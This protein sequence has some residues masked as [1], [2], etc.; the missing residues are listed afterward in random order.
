MIKHPCRLWRATERREGTRKKLRGATKFMF[1]YDRQYINSF[2]IT[3]M[4]KSTF[5]FL[6]LLL[7][8]NILKYQ[9]FTLIQHRISNRIQIYWD[10]VNSNQIFYLCIEPNILSESIPLKFISYSINNSRIMLYRI[11]RI[12]VIWH[13]RSFDEMLDEMIVGY[14]LVSDP[15]KVS[16][17][18]WNGK[19]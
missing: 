6:I 5:L 7:E 8:L 15:V 18:T 11:S 12:L 1:L 17:D 13:W 4:Q 3:K 16:F 19:N 14:F 9:M 2:E 10:Q